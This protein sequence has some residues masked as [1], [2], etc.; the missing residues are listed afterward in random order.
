M[1]IVLELYIEIKYSADSLKWDEH[2]KNVKCRYLCACVLM[3]MLSALFV[4]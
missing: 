2:I 4:V 3:V 1:G